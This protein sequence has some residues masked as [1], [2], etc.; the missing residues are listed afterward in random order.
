M[1]QLSTTDA[2]AVLGVSVQ[3]VRALA[4]GGDLPHRRTAGGH[5]RFSESDLVSYRA[6]T[7]AR[8]LAPAVRSAV[9]TAAALAVLEEAEADLG[10][11]TPMAE[12][13]RR[14]ARELVSYRQGL[15]GAPG[16]W[17]TPPSR[18]SGR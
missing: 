10:T 9:W 5:R 11:G 12:P 4:D 16:R 18:S 8:T 7:T 13:F 17:A 2:A 3:T 1:A 15:R 14:A 6:R